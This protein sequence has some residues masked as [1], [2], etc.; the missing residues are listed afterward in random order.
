ETPARRVPLLCRQREAGIPARLINRLDEP[1]AEA[2]LADDQSTIVILNGAR[3]NL[4]C[5]GARGI[6]QDNEWKEVIG[7]LF[8]RYVAL[9][10]SLDAAARLQNQLPLLKKC[11]AD[12][13]CRRKHAT[14]IAAQIKDEA[15]HV[16]GIELAK[17]VTKFGAA[18]FRKAVEF[19][20]AD[21]RANH[22][23]VV[24]RELCDL[25][26]DRR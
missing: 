24:D 20:I 17:G 8:L 7:V 12:F 9:A 11:F 2:C 15:V 10:R 14:G 13:D 25:V 22:E 18:G 5:A 6:N 4:R 3:N 23:G 1:F 19:D 21:A 26:A 16:L